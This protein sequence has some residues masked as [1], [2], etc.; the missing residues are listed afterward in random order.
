MSE[1]KNFLQV[2]SGTEGPHFDVAFTPPGKF[3]HFPNGSFLDF[4]Q[5]QDQLIFR[6]KLGEPPSEEF[7]CLSRGDCGIRMPV[8]EIPL[9]TIQRHVFSYPTFFAKKIV[10]GGYRNPRQPMLERRIAAELGKIPERPH[11]YLL[12]DV[13]QLV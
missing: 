7:A 6:R 3:R 4:A 1:V 12:T 9:R 11:E 5:G 8:T 2:L 10:A 13:V